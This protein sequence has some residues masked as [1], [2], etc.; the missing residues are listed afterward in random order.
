MS[1]IFRRCPTKELLGKF[2]NCF[3]GFDIDEFDK[4]DAFY[5]E[6]NEVISHKTRAMIFSM[7]NE[8]S[9]FFRPCKIKEKFYLYDSKYVL[10]LLRYLMDY[11]DLKLSYKTRFVCY[12]NVRS[13]QISR[14]KKAYQDPPA[15]VHIER[16]SVKVFFDSI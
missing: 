1:R 16:K 6:R 7:K 3:G 8:L 14:N 13:Y 11:F 12:K 10:Q 4:N 2:L 5:F 15:I 9:E